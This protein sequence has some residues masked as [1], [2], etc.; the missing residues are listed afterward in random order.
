MDFRRA[1][2]VAMLAV[3]IGVAAAPQSPENKPSPQPPATQSPQSPQSPAS[4]PV[5]G[6]VTCPAPTPPA[7]LPSRSFMAPAGMLLIPVLS[8]KVDDFEKFLGYVRDALAKTTDAA[9]REQ[10]KGLRFYKVPETGPNGDVLFAMLAE[11]AVPCVD[12]G[13]QA[14]LIPAIP[15]QKQLDEVWSLYRNSVRNGGHLMNFVPVK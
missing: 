3:P 4:Q 10:A 9:L 5:Q 14:I 13:F 11:A 12:Y 7:T 1:V 2:L 15:D 6:T 8:T